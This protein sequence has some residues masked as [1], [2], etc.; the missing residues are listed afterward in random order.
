M[1]RRRPGGGRRPGGPGGDGPGH[2]RPPPDGTFHGSPGNGTW[3]GPGRGFNPW[4]PSEA[5]LW[6]PKCMKKNYILEGDVDKD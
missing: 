1:G 4:A 5:G 6:K 2:G 3:K